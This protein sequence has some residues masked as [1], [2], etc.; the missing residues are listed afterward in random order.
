MDPGPVDKTKIGGLVTVSV[1]GS[2]DVGLALL[3]Q[4][5]RT[6]QVNPGVLLAG[7]CGAP[8]PHD[9][10]GA[11]VDCA[12]ESKE[13]VEDEGCDEEE[14]EAGGEGGSGGAEGLGSV[15]VHPGEEELC[16]VGASQE[17]VCLGDQVVLVQGVVDEVELGDEPDGQADG[18]GVLLVEE[19]GSHTEG[20]H[21]AVLHQVCT[22]DGA[23]DGDAGTVLSL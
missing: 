3:V 15:K 13:P 6:H 5:Q 14:G 21:P 9:G 1:H 19:V 17:V 7:G 8:A 18:R 23:P 10:G 4:V 22:V 20:A 12:L 16:P 11:V 2:I